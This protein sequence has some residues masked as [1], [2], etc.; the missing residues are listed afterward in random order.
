MKIGA[1]ACAGAHLDTTTILSAEPEF[2]P[3]V[4]S[5]RLI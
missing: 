4:V 2:I 5:A 3:M 1:C